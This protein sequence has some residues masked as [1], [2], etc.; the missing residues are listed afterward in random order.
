MIRGFFVAVAVSIVSLFG[1]ASAQ[2]QTKTEEF[3]A[4][5]FYRAHGPSSYVT[6][7]GARVAGHLAPTLSATLDYGHRP[8]VL[9][10][11]ECF[12]DSAVPCTNSEL[13][14]N[15]GILAL[16]AVASITLFDSVEV[17]LNLPLVLYTRGNGY[18]WTE[19][20]PPTSRF[21]LGGDAAGI[22][23]PRLYA[24]G[25]IASVGDEHRFHFGAGGWLTLPIGQAVARGRFIGDSTLSLGFHGIA[26]YVFERFSGAANL[27]IAWRDEQTFVRSTA[28]TEM[29]WSLAA[30]YA[31]TPTFSGIVEIAGFTSFGTHF[32]SEA[33]IE[34]LASG[35]L[36]VGPV[37]IDSGL[38][39]GLVYGVG[40][41][42]FRVF[43]GASWSPP[44]DMDRDGDGINDGRDGCPTAAEDMDGFADDDG[45]PD[46]D[47]D[48]DGLRP[49]RRTNAPTTQKTKTVPMMQT[50]A[51]K[52]TATATASLTTS[53]RARTA[54]RISTVTATMTGARTTTGTK[55]ASTTMWIGA[56][57]APRIR[58]DWPTG[59]AAQKGMRIMTV[60]STKRTNALVD[61]R[62]ATAIRTG[63][64][65][66]NEV[67]VAF[68]PE[69][70]RRKNRAPG[71]AGCR[72]NPKG[73]RANG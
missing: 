58:T 29:V 43:V 70:G 31:L 13:D 30:T 48:H 34:L 20:S 4:F 17:A 14:V 68:R 66:P 67:V 60:S 46:A 44:S 37:V 33:P 2:A 41:P 61:V 50:A 53:T 73:C 56:R 57:I 72:D 12:V 45:C 62:T 22:A 54:K 51:R 47:N 7:Y 71:Q 15:N 10:N 32:D 36:D 11:I 18:R 1:H 42:D 52:R 63:T 24:R 28:G 23:D 35:R 25:H 5:R 16:Q 59:T 69:D 49:T 40:V 6:S 65:A 26:E 9:D 19:G 27:G 55:T 64:G 8:Y 21:F 39:V 38:G 3:S